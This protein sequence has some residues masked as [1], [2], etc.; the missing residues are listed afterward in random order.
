MVRRIDVLTRLSS[1]VLCFVSVV[2]FIIIIIIVTTI[3][4]IVISIV[5]AI[6]IVIVIIFTIIIIL[7]IDVLR[8]LVLDSCF[9]A[10]AVLHPLLHLFYAGAGAYLPFGITSKLS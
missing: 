10:V 9:A 3:I 2:V 7:I 1:P 4:I 5:V 8:L 6:I